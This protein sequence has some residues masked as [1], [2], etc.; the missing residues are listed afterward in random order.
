[1]SPN[2]AYSTSGEVRRK[3]TYEIKR[4]ISSRNFKFTLSF[5]YLFI[6]WKNFYLVSDLYGPILS[7][8]QKSRVLLQLIKH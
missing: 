7:S 2:Y 8:F 5:D 1:M 3:F 6:L 4:K